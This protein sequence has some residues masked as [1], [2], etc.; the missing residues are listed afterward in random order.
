[1][2]L[3]LAAGG[4]EARLAAKVDRRDAPA[5]TAALIELVRRVAS[6]QPLDADSGRQ[7]DVPLRPAARPR[8]GR[9]TTECCAPPAGMPIA[10]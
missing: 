2:F 5:R 7:L 1:M 4:S 9:A 6:G 3:G 10:P 8:G